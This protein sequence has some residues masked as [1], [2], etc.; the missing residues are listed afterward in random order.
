MHAKA[1]PFLSSDYFSL[2]D[3]S[4][5]L[6]SAFA[7]GER[8]IAFAGSTAYEVVASDQPGDPIVVPTAIPPA[9]QTSQGSSPQPAPDA[10]ATTLPCAGSLLPLGFVGLAVLKRRAT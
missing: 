5:D 4:P 7:L 9:T 10:R 6:A 2:A 1:V 3:S 8:V